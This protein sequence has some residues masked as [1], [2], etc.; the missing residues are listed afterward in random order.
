MPEKESVTIVPF[1][2]LERRP[3][4]RLL[5]QAGNGHHRARLGVPIGLN[6]LP[7]LE[8]R[9]RVVTYQEELRKNGNHQF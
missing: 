6:R 3:L 9:P 2:Q 5:D 1:S 7:S 8:M 4:V